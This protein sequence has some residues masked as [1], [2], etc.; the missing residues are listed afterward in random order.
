VAVGPA[1]LA[2][3]IPAF[4]HAVVALG[5]MAA[6]TWLHYA[7]LALTP[8]IAALLWRD[9]EVHRSAPVLVSAGFGMVAI[10]VHVGLHIGAHGHHSAAFNLANQAGLALLTLAVVLNGRALLGRRRA[11]AA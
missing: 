4:W 7:A 5:L 2:C 6:A 11:A 3:T 10:A 9:W 1:C 8:V